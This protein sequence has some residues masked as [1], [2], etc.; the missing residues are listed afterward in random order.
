LKEGDNFGRYRR[1]LE[2][3]IEMDLQEICCEG[4]DWVHV[5][6][7]SDKWRAVMNAIIKFWV[8]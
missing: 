5:D 8:P 7:D 4:I 3:D 2:D 1:R 6:K